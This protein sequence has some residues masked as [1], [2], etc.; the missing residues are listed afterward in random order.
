MIKED[1]ADVEQPC[2]WLATLTVQVA[3]IDSAHWA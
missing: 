1:W 3:Q 2:D